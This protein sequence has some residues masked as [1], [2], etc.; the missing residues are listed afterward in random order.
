MLQ[1][2]LKGLYSNVKLLEF[3]KEENLVDINKDE[4]WER[5][6]FLFSIFLLLN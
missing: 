2:C 1:G 5:V 6:C 3:V 4:V